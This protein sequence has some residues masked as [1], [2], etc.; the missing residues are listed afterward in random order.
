MPIEF[1]NRMLSLIFRVL[2]VSIL[3]FSPSIWAADCTAQVKP[4][5]DLQA[6]I[7]RAGKQADPATLCLALS[8][9]HI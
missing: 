7:D 2:A 3:L 5:D 1:L 8:L 4:G 6:A 9:I